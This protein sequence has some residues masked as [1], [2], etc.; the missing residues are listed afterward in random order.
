MKRLTRK[1]VLPLIA[2]AMFLAP[3]TAPAAAVK[4]AVLPFTINAPK[5][6]KYV[7]QGVFDM[8]ATRLAWPGRVQVID[9]TRVT[10]AI[11]RVRGPLTPAKAVKI[12]H[13]LGADYVMYGSIT[14]IGSR[15]SIDAKMINLQN[16]KQV[17]AM[18]TQAKNVDALI[19][20]VNQFA[21]RINKQVFGRGPGAKATAPAAGGG[22]PGLSPLNP[23]Y[24]RIL[25]G[26]ADADIWR[27]PRFDRTI[28]G[29]AMGDLDKD[30]KIEVVVAFKHSLAIY[31]ID[32]RRFI[33]LYKKKVRRGLRH[34][35]VDVADINNNGKP[36]IF[37][38]GLSGEQV[39][40]YVIEYRGGTYKTIVKESDWFFRVI[41][42]PMRKP[43]LYGQSKR[44]GVPYA[45]GTLSLLRWNGVKYIAASGAGFP[46]NINIF[47]FALADI[48]RSGSPAIVM[49]NVSSL[50]YVLRPNGQTLWEGESYYSRSNKATKIMVSNGSDD[51]EKY[52]YFPARIRVYDLNH[53]G[54]NEILV[55]KHRSKFLDQIT[56]IRGTLNHG[57]VICYVWNKISL[58]ELFRS[59]RLSGRTVDFVVGKVHNDGT[60]RILIAIMQK[61]RRGLFSREYG[62]LVS[63]KIDVSKLFGRRRR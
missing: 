19:P 35:F 51:V 24:L 37:V 62:H 10:A 23:L 49:V 43:M 63:F 32:K 11:E 61:G 54:M 22:G 17:M 41:R 42:I 1:M 8:L 5:S 36:E 4:V 33:L 34:L 3:Q 18:S 45:K 29:L 38:T 13:F 52:F 21:K 28:A 27:S 48:D 2:A 39:E 59:Q 6:L 56:R 58:A 16:K 47:N 53:D 30:G 40:S 31:R 7:R 14:K 46:R 55:I 44:V 57:S 9:P 60:T 26:L 12:G 25:G 50:L 15:F 20:K